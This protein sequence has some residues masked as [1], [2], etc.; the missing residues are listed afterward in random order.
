MVEPTATETLVAVVALV[1]FVILALIAVG[2]MVTGVR[3][4]LRRD[5]NVNAE[6]DARILMAEYLHV[7][8]DPTA[9]D[10]EY[11]AVNEARELLQ[12]RQ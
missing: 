4:A 3:G 5:R 8:R 6:I 7:H 12:R 2:A 9:P 10:G 1:V 11:G